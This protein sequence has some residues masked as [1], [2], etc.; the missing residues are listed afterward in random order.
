[1]GWASPV[2]VRVDGKMVCH[3]VPSGSAF[4]ECA[5][6]SKHRG[7]E[8]KTTRKS[9]NGSQDVDRREGKRIHHA[10]ETQDD[11]P[12]VVDPPNPEPVPKPVPCCCC[13]CC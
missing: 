8:V 7:D 4:T 6:S 1:M 3:S 2:S 5:S 12:P 13:C 11:L 9:I 10:K